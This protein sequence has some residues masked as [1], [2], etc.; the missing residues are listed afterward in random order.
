MKDIVV[1]GS[2]GFSKQVIE[3]IEKIN[4]SGNDEYNISGIIDDDPSLIGKKVLGY[5]IIGTTKELHRHSINNNIYC[6][7]AI[8]DG[9]VRKKI[10][11][12]L[13][14]VKWANLI[15]PSAVLSKYIKLGVGNVICGGVVMNPECILGDHC[16]I[17][18]GTTLGHDVLMED[19]I[20]V[21]PGSRVS[22]NVILKS[23]SM[24]GTGSTVLQGLTIEEDVIIGAGAVV[25]KDTT[26]NSV[27][28]GVPAKKTK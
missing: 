12:D 25:T 21:M 13:S 15:H 27:Y 3:I 20:T 6:V 10:S 4:I 18:I 23:G 19:F 14:Y 2:G 11:R 5:D 26:N 17:N 28:I 8:A 9:E 7:I 16:H 1:I 22:G 24:I